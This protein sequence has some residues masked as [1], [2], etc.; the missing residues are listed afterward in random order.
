MTDDRYCAGTKQST[1]ANDVHR[2][3]NDTKSKVGMSSR[4]SIAESAAPGSGAQ[5]VSIAST[6]NLKKSYG[7][8]R[9]PRE[10]EP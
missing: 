3:L 7:N 4:V 8:D 10:P 6:R 2:N 9:R 5:P 1:G